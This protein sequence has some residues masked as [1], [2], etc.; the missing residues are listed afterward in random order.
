MAIMI[1]PKNWVYNWLNLMFLISQKRKLIIIIIGDQ[2]KNKGKRVD[3]HDVD[4]D[5]DDTYIVHNEDNC[6][7]TQKNSEELGINL[8]N[9]MHKI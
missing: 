6:D 7:I 3:T 5:K 2:S 1:I 4:H 9:L 8:P